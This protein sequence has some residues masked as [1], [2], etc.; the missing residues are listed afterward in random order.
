VKVKRLS[1]FVMACV[2]LMYL[3]GCVFIVAGTLGAVGGYVITSDTIQGEYDADYETAWKASLE[4][5]GVLGTIV[6]R[7]ANKGTLDA[8]ID[9]AKVKVNIIRLTPEAIRVKVKA[10]KGIF[11]RRGTAENVFVKIIQRVK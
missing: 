8:T 7:D 6:S 5:C 11:P 4:V 3:S 10:R 9:H 2:V 1:L